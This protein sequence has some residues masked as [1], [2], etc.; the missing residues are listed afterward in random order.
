MEAHEL[1]AKWKEKTLTAIEIE[2]YLLQN[3]SANHYHGSSTINHV[4]DLCYQIY[5]WSTGQIL[6]VGDFLQAIINNDLTEAVHRADELNRTA[7]W[8]YVAFLYNVAP[9]DWKHTK[10]EFENK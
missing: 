2:R 4:A 3:T 10:K 7:L 5:L 1:S 8:L 6:S 9:G